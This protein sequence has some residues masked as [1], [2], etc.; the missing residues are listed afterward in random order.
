VLAVCGERLGAG[1][2]DPIW[3]KGSLQEESLLIVAVG[4]VGP[5]YGRL[6]SEGVDSLVRRF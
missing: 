5:I 1:A 6:L 2:V 3:V 4:F